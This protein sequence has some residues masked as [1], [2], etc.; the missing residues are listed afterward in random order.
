VQGER[1][2][3]ESGGRGEKGEAEVLGHPVRSFGGE[4]G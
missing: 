3:E 4:D 1:E 2:G